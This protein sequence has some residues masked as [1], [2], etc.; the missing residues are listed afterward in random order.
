MN[1]P[2][3]ATFFAIKEKSWKTWG[4]RNAFCCVSNYVSKAN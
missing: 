3:E 4:R 2:S 1:L